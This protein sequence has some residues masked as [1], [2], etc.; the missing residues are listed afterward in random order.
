[1]CHWWSF[2]P[3]NAGRLDP[4][5]QHNPL[6]Q[7]AYCVT[8]T[9]TTHEIP[10][11]LPRLLLCN[12]LTGGCF[13]RYCRKCN[14]MQALQQQ[15]QF[16]APGSAQPLSSKQRPRYL[17]QLTSY[18]GATYALRPVEVAEYAV[19]HCRRSAW[20]SMTAALCHAGS[21]KRMHIPHRCLDQLSRRRRRWELDWQ[22]LVLYAPM[23]M[24]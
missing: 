17:A 9:L 14:M 15:L 1:M 23:H 11:P 12:L 3:R 4:E 6:A 20:Q 13:Q 8:R 5:T 10:W 2:G 19:L 22:L 24:P 18:P 21:R 16:R 7:P